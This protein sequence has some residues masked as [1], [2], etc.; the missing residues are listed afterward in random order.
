[1]NRDATVPEVPQII[2]TPTNEEPV[3]EAEVTTPGD[4]LS[5]YFQSDTCTEINTCG[6]KADPDRDGLNNK[7]EYD[8]STDPN[9]QDSDGDGLADGDEKLIFNTDPLLTR[10]YRE[11][12]YSDTDFV[13]G[14]YSIDTNAPYTVTELADIK[15]K[16]KDRGLHQ[17]TLAT[18]G[19]AALDI[20][21][22]SDPE[23]PQ[24]PANIDQ[25]AE[26]KLD[27]DTQRQSTIKKVGAA[28]IKYR[29]AK[30]SFP[31]AADF[32]AMADM[33]KPYNTVATNYNDPINLDRFVYTYQSESNNTDFTL[34]YYSETQYQLIKYKA[35]DAEA[36]A[37]KE[38]TQV[39]D[40]QRRTDLENIR[41]A[42][43]IYSSGQV[44]SNSPQE[45]VFPT[46]EQYPSVLTPRYL[47]TVPKDPATKL[48]YSYQVGEQFNT[49]T[50]KAVL[51]N[52][53]AGTTGY[54]CNQD[55]CR[56]Y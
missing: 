17:P 44:D 43:L 14:G 18:L 53:A 52:P 47:V 11:G 7:E 26:A 46:V 22:F 39:A 19:E 3:A 36:T 45:Y 12:E 21:D 32:V 34:T 49:F 37:Q 25:S 29:D 33:I 5:R 42:L 2:E 9:N 51:D 28:L 55:E 6:D 30:K 20:Y 48:D 16:V 4:W 27:R 41:N 13:K 10:T 40:E 54:M 50:L 31:P 8:S 38:N 56:N 23:A 1:M 15:A 35:K 24:L